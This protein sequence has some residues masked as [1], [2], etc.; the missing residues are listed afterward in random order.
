MLLRHKKYFALWCKLLEKLSMSLWH[1]KNYSIVLNIQSSCHSR[2]KICRKM[3]LAGIVVMLLQGLQYYKYST[4]QG[5]LK[6][7]DVFLYGLVL[8]S[9]I[10]PH[11]LLRSFFFEARSLCTLVKSNIQLWKTSHLTSIQSRKTSWCERLCI[12]GAY[13]ILPS[14]TVYPIAVVFGLHWHSPCKPS[15]MGYFLLFECS[16]LVQVNKTFAYVAQY[17]IKLIVFSVN[18]MFLLV[19]TY[20]VGFSVAVIEIFCVSSFWDFL[21]VFEQQVLKEERYK[22]YRAIQILNGLFNE[23]TQQVITPIVMLLG[24]LV[25]A[26]STAGIVVVPFNREHV[27]WQ[28]SLWVLLING[29]PVVILLL[30]NMASVHNASRSI[31]RK[32]RLCSLAVTNIF[33]DSM[34]LKQNYV[35]W[36]RKFYISCRPIIFKFSQS[37]FVGRLTPLKCILIANKISGKLLLLANK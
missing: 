29:I 10:P 11:L 13:A 30:G 8:L 27:I 4:N 21:N 31:L 16:S 1:W 5:N 24:L 23:V 18:S 35:K 33:Y 7:L 14:V 15:L 36:R 25:V 34:I 20:C 26:V 22:Y 12:I 19:S 28:L 9:T 17:F 37:N 2:V 32:Q 6:F 3:H